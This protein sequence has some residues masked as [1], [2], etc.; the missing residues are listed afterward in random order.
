ML[1]FKDYN[2]PQVTIPFMRATGRCAE[3]YEIDVDLRQRIQTGPPLPVAG[4]FFLG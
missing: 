1:A 4:A 3:E 2:I